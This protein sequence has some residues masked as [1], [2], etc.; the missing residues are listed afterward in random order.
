MQTL[1]FKTSINGGGCLK[2]EPA[3]ALNGEPAIQHWQVDT[4]NPNKILTVSTDL[5]P[6]QVRA[7]VAEA[8]FE[9][10]AA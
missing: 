3:P 9:A 6:E 1:Q 8:G 7:L 2:A 5:S 4:T 10:Q